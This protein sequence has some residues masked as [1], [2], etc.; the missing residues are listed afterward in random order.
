MKKNLFKILDERKIFKLVLGLG[1]QSEE[2]IISNVE[3]YARSGCDMFDVNASGKAIEAVYKG[4]EKAGKNKEDFLVCLSIG[5]SGDAHI[6]K[7]EIIKEKCTRCSACVNVCPQ[8]AI[9]LLNDGY[10]FVQKEKCIGCKRCKCKAISFFEKESDFDEALRLAEK[11]D[12]DCIEVHL[13]SKKPPYD[14]LKYLI[15][16]AKTPLSFCL[17]RK[18]YSNEKIRKIVSKIKKWLGNSDFIIQ[19]DGVPMSGGKNDFNSTLQ[20]VAMAHIVKEYGTYI[21]LS[22][23]TNEKTA[24]L[25]KMCDIKYNGIG[26]GSYAREIIKGKNIED[27]VKAAENLVEKCK[28]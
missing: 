5:V 6:N 16:N 15:R 17:D 12:I 19:A 25:A 7:A 1:N 24:Q 9:I 14:K 10:P 13:A 3:V 2:S 22:G 8:D 21:I 11:Y 27:A 28:E 18:Y 4:I 20:A 26:V 23:G